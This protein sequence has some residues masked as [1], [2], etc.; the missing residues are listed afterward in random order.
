MYLKIPRTKIARIEI[1][2]TDCKLTLQQVVAQHKCDA[3]INGGLYSMKTG[4]VVD[5][6]LRINGKTIANHSDGYWCLAWNVGSDIKMI[7]SKDMEKYKNVLACSAMLKGGANTIFNYQPDQGGVRGRTGIGCDHDNLHLFVS[8]DGNGA[9][10]PTALRSKMKSNGCLDA[11]MLDAG[12]SSQMY[13]G[14]KYYQSERR[15]VS[16]WICVWY[17]KDTVQKPVSPTPV[18]VACPYPVPTATLRR[19]NTGNTV[20]WV[21]WHLAKTVAPTI[22]A[23]GI[24]GAGTQRA[25]KK[26]QAKYGLAVDG[27]VGRATREKM[28]EVCHG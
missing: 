4:K 19:G 12:G 7:H 9:L 13:D 18:P 22:K 26:F 5:I 23:D 1:V 6:P 3:A 2:K 28:Q 11:I 25:A 17:K 8:N 15:R 10:S 21:Q 20:R 27:I 24:F 16:Y 14:K